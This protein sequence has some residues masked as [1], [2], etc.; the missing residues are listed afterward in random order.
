MSWNPLKWFN[1]KK[2]EGSVPDTDDE[3][4]YEGDTFKTLGKGFLDG[5]LTGD[6]ESW[7]DKMASAYADD[8]KWSHLDKGIKSPWS[9]EVAEGFTMAYP[10]FET[11][12]MVIPGAEAPQSKSFLQRLAGAGKGFLMGAATGQPHMAGVG[13]FGGFFG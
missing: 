7:Q 5:Y 1:K 3:K 8:K 12:A 13:A 9:S 11:Q 6:K 2:D 10:P 4:W